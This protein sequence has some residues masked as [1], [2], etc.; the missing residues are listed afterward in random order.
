MAAARGRRTWNLDGGEE[1]DDKEDDDG[2]PAKGMISISSVV[3][4]SLMICIIHVA[5]ALAPVVASP[6]LAAQKTESVAPANEGD[7][8]DEGE[9]AGPKILSKKEK[10]KLKKEREKASN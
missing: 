5:V 2:E 9:D 10:E 1:E 4:Y 7:G 8:S 3:Q 6:A